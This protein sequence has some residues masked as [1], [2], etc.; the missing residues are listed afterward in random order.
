M[1]GFTGWHA[2]LAIALLG[3][4][5]VIAALIARSIFQ[6]SRQTRHDTPSAPHPER[7]P[8]RTG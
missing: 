3:G 8:Q 7:R 4:T 2:L 1:W 5:L 6:A